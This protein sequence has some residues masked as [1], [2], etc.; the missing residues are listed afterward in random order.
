MIYTVGN[1]NFL[2]NSENKLMLMFNYING[3]DLTVDKPTLYYKEGR[4]CVLNKNKDTQIIIKDV[5]PEIIKKFPNTKKILVIE[6]HEASI[7]SEYNAT[8]KIEV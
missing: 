1:H 4:D 5:H 3:T 8:V 6:I 2:V 7:I